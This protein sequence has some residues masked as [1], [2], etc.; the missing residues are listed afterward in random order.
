MARV[1]D[2][3]FPLPGV[4]FDAA[5]IAQK[6]CTEVVGWIESLAEEEITVVE[7]EMCWC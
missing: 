4:E 7:G 2:V 5:R 3:A 1:E 6:R